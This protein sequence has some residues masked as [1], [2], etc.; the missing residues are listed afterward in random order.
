MWYTIA[1]ALESRVRI[2]CKNFVPHKLVLIEN[3]N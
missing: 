1:V 2:K 3:I